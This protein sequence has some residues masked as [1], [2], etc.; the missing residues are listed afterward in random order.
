[1][2]HSTRMTCLTILRQQRGSLHRRELVAPV[3]SMFFVSMAA[4][5]SGYLLVLN[6]VRLK[7]VQQ[8]QHE[9]RQQV[10]AYIMIQPSKPT[11]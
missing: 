9:D 11:L 10:L 7:I 6:W 3:F 2:S 8:A 1:M 5:A 4:A